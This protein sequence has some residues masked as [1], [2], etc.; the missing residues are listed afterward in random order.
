MEF[1]KNYFE[2]ESSGHDYYH[3]LRVY[4]TANHILETEKAD[5]LLVKLA[6]LLHDVDDIKISP[7]TNKNKDNARKFLSMNNVD[8]DTSEKVCDIIG[9]ISYKGIE[10]KPSKTIEGKIVQDA[11]SLSAS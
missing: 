7:N 8:K 4:N 1:V 6:A 11:S 2:N 10:T 3:T 5:K 9:E